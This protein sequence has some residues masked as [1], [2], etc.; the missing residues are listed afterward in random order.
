[1]VCAGLRDVYARFAHG[2]RRFTRCLRKVY[3]MFT[4]RELCLREV[5]ARFTHG[6]RRVL[7]VYARF[8]QGLRKV[9]ADG[10]LITHVRKP[11]VN[12]FT[13]GLRKVYAEGNLL[14]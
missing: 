7:K 5:C 9:Y 10:V 1:M 14:M 4:Q 11:R 6:L 13:Q 2:L 12:Q 3:A 8:T